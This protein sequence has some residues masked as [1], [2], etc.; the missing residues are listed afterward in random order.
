MSAKFAYFEYTEEPVKVVESGDNWRASLFLFVAG[1][2]IG[3]AALFKEVSA[4]KGRICK[5]S[6]T[7]N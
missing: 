3:G 5:Q 2:W 1:G 7:E 6:R 4:K